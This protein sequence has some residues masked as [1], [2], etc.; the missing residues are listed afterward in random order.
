M[1]IAI[2][3]LER[4]IQDLEKNTGGYKSNRVFFIIVTCNWNR[5]HRAAQ[6]NVPQPETLLQCA[7]FV[8]RRSLV[9]TTAWGNDSARNTSFDEY[10]SSCWSEMFRSLWFLVTFKCV[11]ELL[12]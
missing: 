3:S 1:G 10:G 9:F 5:K 4:L 8:L 2:E 11:A 6:I 12:S 7:A